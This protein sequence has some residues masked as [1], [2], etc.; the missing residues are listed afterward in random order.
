MQRRFSKRC[1]H[2]CNA[3]SVVRKI[4]SEQFGRR[5]RARG[6]VREQPAAV[7]DCDLKL[8]ALPLDLG[9]EFPLMAEFEDDAA[10]VGF[11]DT[12]RFALADEAPGGW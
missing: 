2:D 4:A 1:D 6:Q 9:D 8:V 10:L 3:V 12:L 7:L 11:E 5:S